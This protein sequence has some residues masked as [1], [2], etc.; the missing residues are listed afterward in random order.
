MS[1]DF[2]YSQSITADDLNNIAVDLGA[3]TFTA[4]ADNSPYAVE[5][6]NQITSALVGKGISTKGDMFSLSIVGDNFIIS[7]GTAFFESG[8]KYTLETPLT[9]PLQAGEIYLLED[10][11]TG[12]VSLHV[13]SLPTSHYIQL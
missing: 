1:T 5:Q 7:S 9:I 2:I 12:N 4:F 13:G 11:A 10:E 3:G 8:R 6:L